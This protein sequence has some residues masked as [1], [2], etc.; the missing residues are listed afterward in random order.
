MIRRGTEAHHAANDF[1]LFNVKNTAQ[2]LSEY[3]FSD[4]DNVPIGCVRRPSFTV[5]DPALHGPQ[6]RD[7]APVPSGAPEETQVGWIQSLL[8]PSMMV[9]GQ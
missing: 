6:D 5:F 3:W 1:S 2:T 4:C 7:C 8:Y 9:I